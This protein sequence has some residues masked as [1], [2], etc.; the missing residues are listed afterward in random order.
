MNIVLAVALLTG[1]YM[2]KYQQIADADLQAVIGHV[3]PDSPAA[4]AGIQ[5]AIASFRWTTSKDPNWEDI[6]LKEMTSAAKP[7]KI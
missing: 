4:K 1:L 6:G 3:T 2:V 7:L 5:A